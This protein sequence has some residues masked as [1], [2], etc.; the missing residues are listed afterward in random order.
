MKFAVVRSFYQYTFTSNTASTPRQY[1]THPYSTADLIVLLGLWTQRTLTRKSTVGSWCVRVK[2]QTYHI[3][4]SNTQQPHTKGVGHWPDCIF[5]KYSLLS[6]NKLVVVPGF[7]GRK[8]SITKQ[9]LDGNLQ[10]LGS[11][12]TVVNYV[13]TPC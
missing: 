3:P 4:G 6:T 9:F 1:N 8:L 2:Q 12:T 7:G 5:L 13:S 10:F 11:T